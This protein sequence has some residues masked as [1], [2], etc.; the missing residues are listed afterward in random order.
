MK[1]IDLTM[2]ISEDT[3]V[4]SGDPKPRIEQLTTFS[5]H[6]W[7]SKMLSFTSHF[8]THMDAPFHMLE[9]GKKLDEFPPETFFGEG[10]V[11]D[12]K[13]PDLDAVKEGDIIF[14]Y[15]SSKNDYVGE[16][17]LS[18]E[19]AREL[20]RK[21]VKMV[22]LDSFGPDVPPYEIHKLFFSNDILLVENLINLK[23]IV[24]KRC[25]FYVFPLKIKDADGA[26]C[27]AIAIL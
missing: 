14:F 2:H 15:S 20:V 21:K 4:Y 7:N 11:L 18:M 17:T 1:V 10:I 25:T 16:P 3:P 13:N 8:G 19:L 22:G 27:R 9:K 24:G 23:E 26:P 12:S 6:G 5:K